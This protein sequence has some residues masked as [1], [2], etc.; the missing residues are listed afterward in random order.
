MMASRQDVTVGVD[1]GTTSVKAVA[2]DSRGSVIAR[3]RIPHQV[4]TP[5]PGVLEHDVTKAW[6]RGPRRAFE[7]VIREL[8]GDPAGVC[9]AAMVPSFTAVTRRGTPLLPGLLYGDERGAKP[10]PPEED[11]IAQPQD[12]PPDQGMA[13]MPE[14]VGFIHWAAREAPEAAGYWPCQ[15]VA[16]HALSGVGAIDTTVM[17][18]LGEMQ[19]FGAWNRNVLD[20]LGVETT[21]MPTV[22]PMCEAGGT[23]PGTDTVF[24]GGTVDALGDQLVSGA[25]RVGDVL[26]IFGATLVIWIVTDAWIESPGLLTIPHT[27]PDR[28]LIGGPSNAGALFVDWVQRLLP[29]R[30]IRKG[31]PANPPGGPSLLG[32]RPADPLAIPVWLPYVRGERAPFHDPSLRASLHRL[33][34]GQEPGDVERASFEASG[35]VIRRM[36]D[37]AGV[38]GR[39]VVASGGGTQVPA[40]M[41]GVA[42][43]TGLPVDVV[44]VPEGAAYGAAF[45]AR[46]AAGRAGS[47]EEADQ[48]SQVGR[49]YEPDPAWA[50]AATD[51][52]RHFIELGPGT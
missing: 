15:A 4:F 25:T 50:I 47:L 41:A 13:L 28:M 24:A 17:A 11:I 46:M 51:R 49:R 36:L 38:E 8:D 23:L 1:I 30:A 10:A 31:R 32:D 3:S 34:I 45:V 42:D 40:W 48:W 20:P 12:R 29:S 14:A 33:D 16:T 43:A 5:R 37:Q 35:F 2:V 22:V 39:R 6:R 9:V 21:Q 44:A 7:A 19:H 27:Y 18:S 26:A 52:Y